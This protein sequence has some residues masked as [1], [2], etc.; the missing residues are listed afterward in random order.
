MFAHFLH[1]HTSLCLLFSFPLVFGQRGNDNNREFIECFQRPKVF[2]GLKKDMECVNTH[3][4]VSG[5]KIHSCIYTIIKHSEMHI[6][7][8]TH[9]SV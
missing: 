5:V 2:Y 8:H 3:T 4:Q 6:H 1:V 7:K 9:T